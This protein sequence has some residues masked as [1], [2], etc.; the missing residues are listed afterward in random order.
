MVFIPKLSKYNIN[1]LI[2][3]GNAS[4]DEFTRG[5]I[6][7]AMVDKLLCSNGSILFLVN[8]FIASTNLLKEAYADTILIRMKGNDF[9]ID[10]TIVDEIISYASLDIL[11]YYGADSNSYEFNIKCKEEFYRRGREFEDKIEFQRKRTLKEDK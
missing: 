8:K 1:A 10:S 9:Y 2:A 11:M 3:L 6:R 4:S 7:S 5:R